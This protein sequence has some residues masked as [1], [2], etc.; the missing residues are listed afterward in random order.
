MNYF[1]NGVEEEKL[2]ILLIKKTIQPEKG[3]NAE[4]QQ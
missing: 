2:L 3:R 1:N 4:A